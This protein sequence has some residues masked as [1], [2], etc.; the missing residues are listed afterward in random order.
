MRIG[1]FNI[2][3]GQNYIKYLKTGKEYI[4]LEA[5]ADFISDLGIEICALNEVRNQENVPGLV[6]QAKVM[7]EHIGYY[8]HFARAIDLPPSFGGEYGNAIISKYP[9]K[10]AELYPISLPEEDQAGTRD[11]EPRVVLVARIDV[12]GKELTVIST[13]FGLN[14]KE[15]EKAYAVSLEAI[16]K[17]D[18]PLVFLGDLNINCSHPIIKKLSEKLTNCDAYLESID[19]TWIGRLTD[20]WEIWKIDHIFS[21]GLKVEKS[22]IVS[23]TLSDHRPCYIDCTFI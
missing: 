19:R 3:H 14:D 7:G 15:K 1:T 23:E 5:M 21:K 4:E 12:S 10:S 17:V 20:P 22:V 18:T 2:Q 8:W 11:Y 6:N 9:I 16:E 13:H